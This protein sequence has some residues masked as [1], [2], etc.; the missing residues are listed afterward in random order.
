[1]A[2]LGSKIAIMMAKT[3]EEKVKLILATNDLKY[4]RAVIEG[5]KVKGLSESAKLQLL[6]GAGETYIIKVIEGKHN[7]IG[8]GL[9]L[10]DKIE[11]VKEN[12]LIKEVLKDEIKIEGITLEDKLDLVRSARLEEAVIDGRVK[13]DGLTISHLIELIKSANLEKEVLI[14]EIKVKGLTAKDLIDL[15]KSAGFEK[16][17]LTGEIKIKGLE[18]KDLIDLIKST[19]SE[20]PVL[21]GQIKVDR[22]TVTDLLDLIHSAKLEQD[23]LMGVIEV[24]GLK[25]EHL[26]DLIKS[27]GLEKKVLTSEISIK[28]LTQSGIVE[29]IKS[30]NLAREVMTGEIKVEGLNKLEQIDLIR[31]ANL[32]R[33]VLLGEIN[34]EGL[35]K[36]EQIQLVSDANLEIEVLSNKI[37]IEGMDVESE[38]YLMGK[39]SDKINSILDGKLEI[40]GFTKDDILKIISNNIDRIRNE[41]K[42]QDLMLETILQENN[43][44]IYLHMIRMV[45]NGELEPAVL[46]ASNIDK[47]MSAK[48]ILGIDTVFAILKYEE[49][50]SYDRLIANPESFKKFYQFSKS[51]FL[52]QPVESLEAIS[53][54]EMYNE[55][56]ELINDCFASKL[57]DKD[58]TLLEAILKEGAIADQITDK[59]QL[60]KF[61]EMRKENFAK[62]IENGDEDVITYL[63]SGMSR[64]EYDE[65]LQKYLHNEQMT[66]VLN[67]F[68]EE[69]NGEFQKIKALRELIK[70]IESLDSEQRKSVLH[71]INNELSCEFEE[72]GSEIADMRRAFQE[73]DIQLKRLY[74]KELSKTL[75]EAKLPEV[76]HDEELGIDMIK[77]DG[78]DFTLL[79]HMA[80]QPWDFSEEYN[81]AYRCTSLI[82]P[83]HMQRYMGSGDYCFVF[84]NVNPS[85]L[86]LE[87]SHAHLC[88]NSKIH[89]TKVNVYRYNFTTA[90]NII[91]QSP[92]TENNEID[93]W[94]E[95]IDENGEK[96]KLM[97]TH[98]A[99]FGDKI[100]PIQ[101]KEFIDEAKRLN[102]PI[103]LVDE[104]KYKSQMMSRIKDQDK[105]QDT[106]VRLAD[107]SMQ[108]LRKITEIAPEI[109]QVDF[110]DQVLTE[111]DQINKGGKTNGY[112]K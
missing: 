46:G 51:I 21:T 81:T 65:I 77:L 102:I 37:E 85:A 89:S 45:L 100:D 12:D 93:L 108:T 57:D 33:E 10:E 60:D 91:E 109:A 83:E 35:S 105:N 6:K 55:H 92:K 62:M 50:V 61:P 28:G 20:K 75:E 71:A 107:I 82:S 94:F 34:I 88:S 96:C 86:I 43:N 8:I 41:S 48:D 52:S 44:A 69:Q 78:Q 79:V 27:V 13:V 26:I 38:V 54:I 39:K 70:L 68:S 56:F 76:T 90:S 64:E 101:H 103:I 66:D 3:E 84:Q 15:V 7:E 31:S 30:C 112:E 17:V 29:L 73:V 49:G 106:P 4:I 9:T 11:L 104:E 63:L 99:I 58:K 95:S 22:L 5:E 47:I 2:K 74:G 14:G 110:F 19:N 23:V 32:A 40:D 97:P 36:Y 67:N 1:M 98:M 59:S 24:Q 42:E 111:I 16:E 18:V 80:N 53:I 25:S 87:S 72:Q